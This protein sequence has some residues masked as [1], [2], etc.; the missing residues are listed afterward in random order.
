MDSSNSYKNGNTFNKLNVN[1]NM[2][3]VKLKMSI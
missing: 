3:M 2:Q 1:I